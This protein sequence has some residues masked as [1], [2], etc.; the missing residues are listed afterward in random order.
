MLREL[1]LKM[2][3]AFANTSIRIRNFPTANE[4]HGNLPTYMVIPP[5]YPRGEL[6]IIFA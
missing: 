1:S 6:V 5:I 3:R 2:A 4:A